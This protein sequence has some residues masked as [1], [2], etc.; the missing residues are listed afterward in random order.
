MK[1]NRYL[2]I[3]FIIVIMA[4]SNIYAD[5]WR[6]SFQYLSPIPGAELVNKETTI[7]LRQGKI[8]NNNQSDFASLAI[9]EGSISGN[10][11]YNL[12]ISDD[13]KTIILKPLIPFT[14][15]EIV[16]IDFSENFKI[17]TGQPI[18]DINFKFTISPL[19]PNQLNEYLIEEEFLDY[20]NTQ[21]I[22]TAESFK[23]EDA[24]LDIHPS[25]PS[26]LHLPTVN[27]FNNPDEGYVFVAKHRPLGRTY[28]MIL[29]NTGY[30]VYYQQMRNVV[31]DFKKQPNNLLSYY[32]YGNNFFTVM[33]ST[34]TIIDTY[35]CGNGYN[36]NHH[37]FQ[38]I[39]RG[40]V[41]LIAYDTQLIDMNELVPGGNP[42]CLVKG[43]IIQELDS[44]KNVVFQWRS[45]D[46]FEITDA[47]HMDF[48]SNTL[49]YVH[50]NAIELDNDRNFLISSRHMD[51][52]TKINRHT[53]EIIWRLGGLHN[54][55]EFIGDTCGFS[56]QHDIRR[57]ANGNITLFDNGLFHT[58]QFSRAV[59]YE[60]DEENKTCALVW[61]FRDTPDIF[62][63]VNGSV[64]RLPNGNTMIGWGGPSPITMT[65]VSP[66]GVKEFELS[67][68]GAPSTWS[69]RSFRFPWQGIAQAPYLLAEELNPGFHLIFNKFGDTNV[70]KYYIYMDENPEPTTLVDSTSNTYLDIFQA[71]GGH[72]YY[73]RVTAVDDQATESNYS[74]EIAITAT[75]A[76]NY[77]PGNMNG[78]L[79]IDVGD[80]VFGV[81]YFKGG[82]HPPDSCWNDSSSNWFYCA[83][84]VNGDCW[85]TGSDITYMVVYLRGAHYEL[86]Y[87]PQTPPYDAGGE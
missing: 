42:N 7:I 3:I 9:I 41:L 77:F 70:V 36:A 46:H 22:T 25:L 13:Q 31:T 61:E 20:P 76:Y 59:E 17:I 56:R 1:N 23:S 69:Y 21:N 72:T 40:H 82:S 68:E 45:W 60:L 37:D 55:F 2:I 29:D 24:I 83:G 86:L 85:F 8:L 44:L 52:I 84:D 39:D 34:Y 33:D 87:C 78:D 28:L 80:V 51:E 11:E 63:A 43:L 53:G 30:P 81:N 6:D 50:G 58:P 49:D 16:S 32:L 14:A 66:D 65:E 35:A 19:L 15:G 79:H 74:N 5:S 71:L 47:T 4:I 64:Q 18:G 62:G 48:T 27:I 57:L 73:I 67:L 26:D 10:H 38:M 12:V 75:I 54:E